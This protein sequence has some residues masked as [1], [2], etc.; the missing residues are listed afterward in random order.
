MLA[1][2]QLLQ[3]GRIDTRHGDVRPDAVN[4]QRQQQENQTTL[5]VA[6]FSALSQ[7][8]GRSRHA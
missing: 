5:K 7:L 2:E 3:L 4:D 1:L 8:I 6:E